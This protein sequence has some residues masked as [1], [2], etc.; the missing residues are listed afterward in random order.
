MVD[1]SNVINDSISQSPRGLSTYNVNDLMYLTEA[2]PLESWGNEAYRIY[3]KATD[4]ATDFG[5]DSK[6]YQDAVLI[7][8]QKPNLLAGSGHLLIAPLKVTEPSTVETLSD[9]IARLSPQVYWGGIMFSKEAEVDEIVDAA[10]LNETMDS[11]M[12]VYG[13]QNTDL[14]ENGVLDSILKL[15]LTN[16]KMLYYSMNG[17]TGA[18]NFAAA[19][20]S[21]GMSVNFNAQNSTITM[22]LK[23]L[24]G[25]EADTN[26]NQTLY[27]A[28]ANSGIDCYVS[29][30]G[31][32]KVCSNGNPLFFDDVYNRL[33]FKLRMRVQLFNALATTSTK[34]PQTETGMNKV[35]NAARQVC[36]LAVYNGFCAPGAW[37][38][39]ETFGNQD[40]F[41]RNIEDFGYY[42]YSAPVSEQLQAEREQRIA[43]VIQI[44]VKQAGAIHKIDLILYFE[45]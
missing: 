29:Y 3:V 18:R 38:G 1:I 35:K 21:R 4:V 23:D 40:D 7:F 2:Q 41:Y 39:S 31:L 6:P 8:S 5:T 42:I 44:A 33:W 9:A 22:N 28:L 13:Y 11:I 45:A 14:Q 19:Y 16:T 30:N 43:P 20:A 36:D 27:T 26:I 17:L 10:Q 15:N 37:N 24:S 32:A 34:I 25:I 12:F